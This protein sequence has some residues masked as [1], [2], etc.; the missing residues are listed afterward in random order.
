[1]NINLNTYIVGASPV[2]TCDARAKIVLLIAYSVTL[3][4]VETWRA[5]GVCALVFVALCAM[6]RIPPRR[7]GALSVPIVVIALFAVIANSFS[8]DAATQTA[9]QAMGEEVAFGGVGDVSTGLLTQMPPV[10]LVG[11]FGFVPAGFERGCFYAVRILLLVAASLIVS[12]TTTSTQLTEAFSSF[13]RPLRAL[14]I[15]VDDVASVLSIALRFIPLVAEE[16]GRIHDAQWAR[17]AKFGE[18]GLVVRVRA[19]ATVLVPLF[20]GMFR[21]ADNL[22]VA[23]DARCY[24]APGVRRTSLSHR[25]FGV[26]ATFI[27][28]VGLALCIVLSLLG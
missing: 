1:M 21:R 24:G 11:S 2:H 27:T 22:A 16:M 28:A 23:M 10:V 8:L 18:N 14:R 12:F 26:D 4:L 17:G 7:I 9:A 5:L 19:W 15:P 6:G 13:L 3:F 20:V 25:K